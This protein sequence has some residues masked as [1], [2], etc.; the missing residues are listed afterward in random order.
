MFLMPCQRA[1]V[2]RKRDNGLHL[3][4]IELSPLQSNPGKRFDIKMVV[5][6]VVIGVLV[7]ATLAIYGYQKR[8]I[9][10]AGVS[11]DA[12]EKLDE[13]LLAQTEVQN[14]SYTMSSDSRSATTSGRVA[15]ESDAG[16]VQ[17]PRLSM[18]KLLTSGVIFIKQ[19]HLSNRVIIDGR[20]EKSW[21]FVA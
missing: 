13:Q 16:I 6:T 3:D 7:V 5:A 14:V 11:M 4:N 15:E 9:F 17:E 18:P 21:R 19:G 1:E 12:S 20:C 2:N 8:S 10:N